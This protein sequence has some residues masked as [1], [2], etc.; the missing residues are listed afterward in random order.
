VP[1]AGCGHRK[2]LAGGKQRSP[3]SSQEEPFYGGYNF[4]KLGLVDTE[5]EAK[6][7]FHEATRSRV[8][9]H[10]HVASAVAAYGDS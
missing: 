2:R 7:N 10:R 6:L 8:H 4:R 3:G 9:L 5:P 1:A